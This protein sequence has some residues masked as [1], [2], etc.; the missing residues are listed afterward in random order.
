MFRTVMV[1]ALLAA[2]LV[3]TIPGVSSG[4]EASTLE[5]TEWYLTSYDIGGLEPTEVPW[6]L[7]TAL[8]LDDGMAHGYGGCQ[9]IAGEYTLDG[10]SL[11]F[12]RVGETTDIGCPEQPMEIEAAILA[13]LPRTVRWTVDTPPVPGDRHLILLDADGRHLLRFSSSSTENLGRQVRDLTAL[14]A[15]QQKE[16]RALR[17]RIR[18][19]ERSAELTTGG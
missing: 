8:R 15:A 10:E 14:V 3:V 18:E 17:A 2:A 19:L 11:T 9:S 12:T 13:L 1:R 16:I 5:G 6:D 7:G 4:D